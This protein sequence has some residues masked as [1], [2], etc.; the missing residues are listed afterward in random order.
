MLSV[1]SL[2]VYSQEKPEVRMGGSL[3]MNYRY[4]SWND[5]RQAEGGEFGFDVFQIETRVAYKKV[6]AF[7]DMRFMAENNGG[8]MLKEG[9]VGYDFKNGDDIQVGQAQVPFGNLDYNSYSWYLSSL[10]SMGFEADYDMGVK[11]HHKGA[12]WDW[13]LAFFKNAD[14]LFSNDPDI[15]D[16]RWS[17]DVVGDNKEVNQLNGQL[18]YKIDKE[19][20]KHK[21]GVSAEVGQLYNRVIDQMGSHSAFAVHYSLDAKNI[22]FLAQA[23]TYDYNPKGDNDQFVEVGVFNYTYPMVSGGNIYSAALR[24]KWPV[25]GEGVLEAVDLY[26]E[27]SYTDKRYGLTRTMMNTS[28]VHVKLGQVSTFIEYIAGSN[29]PYLGGGDNALYDGTDT[30]WE[31]RFNINIG[32]YF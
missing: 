23:M 19:N 8:T 30:G 2:G 10:Y 25:K 15:R 13:Q 31:G 22:G 1:M 12:K 32:Y 5:E 21:I 27:F 26:N 18:L 9:W 28:G 29:H 17:T 3:R 4:D 11:Y 20:A 14:E 6:K 24:Y 7:I 16:D